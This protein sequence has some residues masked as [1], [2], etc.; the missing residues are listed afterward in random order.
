MSGGAPFELLPIFQAKLAKTACEIAHGGGWGYVIRTKASNA[1]V[2]RLRLKQATGQ[3][4]EMGRSGLDTFDLRYVH[5]T[6][7][8]LDEILL[9]GYMDVFQAPIHQF[10]E[11]LERVYA[12]VC[13][14]SGQRNIPLPPLCDLRHVPTQH[15]HALPAT[16]IHMDPRAA[17]TTEGG[18]F[19]YTMQGN[20]GEAWRYEYPPFAKPECNWDPVPQVQRPPDLDFEAPTQ[21][22]QIQITDYRSFY[23]AHMA[24]ANY[25][26]LR[27]G[28]TP[29]EYRFETRDDPPSTLLTMS[30]AA[31]FEILLCSC[32]DPFTL[33][34]Q[35]E[36][37]FF[38]T[39]VLPAGYCDVF[40]P[41]VLNLG[42]KVGR[43]FDI[44][45]ACPAGVRFCMEPRDVG[46]LRRTLNGNMN[47][48]IMDGTEVLR[49]SLAPAGHVVMEGNVTVPDLNA[50]IASMG[51]N[52]K[53]A[54]SRHP[55]AHNTGVFKRPLPPRPRPNA[56][57]KP[58]STTA[59][60]AS[61]RIMQIDSE[62]DACMAE[63][64][65]LGAAFEGTD[66]QHVDKAIDDIL[67][68]IPKVKGAPP[69]VN[70][71][72]VGLLK[73]LTLAKDQRTADEK[74]DDAK[75]AEI[76]KIVWLLDNYLDFVPALFEH[77]SLFGIFPLEWA[78]TVKELNAIVDAIKA[79]A[80]QY[81]ADND[82]TQKRLKDLFDAIGDILVGA[83]DAKKYSNIGSYKTYL[84]KVGKLLKRE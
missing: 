23:S 48:R 53:I 46:R 18:S 24:L 34:S 58:P 65:L 41:N 82:A 59:H 12:S 2:M 13:A 74:F 4:V 22:S 78:S 43:L 8:F 39:H 69:L 6:N 27:P 44:R 80:A 64:R 57:F 51:K 11:K 20:A 71:V 14:I 10:A 77:V 83:S 38:I 45:A 49:L 7:F 50:A 21:L 1:V 84:V 76:L 66:A 37:S 40:Q 73:V 68:Y 9:Q 15:G 19:R 67:A 63:M 17:G 61:A 42:P 70:I 31:P 35:E 55:R 62:I 81:K 33:R 3:F 54:P 79:A 32:T 16:S 60:M 29:T 72:N 28:R 47:F 36:V 52:I 26:A 75:F 56:V 30:M 25:L 5:M